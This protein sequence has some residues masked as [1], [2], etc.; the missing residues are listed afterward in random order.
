MT[1]LLSPPSKMILFKSRLSSLFFTIIFLFGAVVSYSQQALSPLNYN[2][3]LQ[4]LNKAKP[5]V[6]GQKSALDTIQVDLVNTRVIFR[7]DFSDYSGWPDTTKW[8]DK[9]AFINNSFGF[10]EFSYGVATFDG[11]DSA[12]QPYNIATPSAYGEN[13][14][15]TSCPI[16]LSVIDIFDPKMDSVYLSFYYQAQGMNPFGTEEGDSLILQFYNPSSLIWSSVWSVDGRP[17]SP[18]RKVTLL[19]DTQYHKN[20]FQ[21]RFVNY[22][23]QTGNVDHW[24]V[25]YVLMTYNEKN[26]H[27][28]VDDMAFREKFPTL[29]KEFTAMPYWHYSPS[30]MKNQVD[31][32]YYYFNNFVLKSSDIKSYLEVL[33][34]N[35][36][37][38]FL[39]STKSPEFSL[40]FVGAKTINLPF[41]PTGNHTYPVSPDEEVGYFKYKFYYVFNDASLDSNRANDTLIENQV[42]GSYYA[43]DDGMAEAGYGVFGSG[44]QLAYRFD[45][46]G[47]T[48]T[49]TGVYIYFTPV[50][51][52]R[53][54][55]RFQ[56]T[57]WNENG[58]TGGPGAELYR[59]SSFD[60][61]K[62]NPWNI[63]KGVSNF[64]YYPLETELVITGGPFY[65]GWTKVTEERMNIGYDVNT[66]S[67]KNI[68]VNIDGVWSQSDSS[69]GVVPGSLMMRPIFRNKKDPVIGMEENTSNDEWKV[70]PNPASNIL[71][72]R[73]VAGS[74]SD[75]VNIQIY[76]ITG[77]L[78][79]S[80]KGTTINVNDLSN[81]LYLIRILD[82]NDR[83]LHHEKLVV[84]H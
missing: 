60:R 24:N 39:D 46:R 59:K 67:Q 6:K 43:Y 8:V 3:H 53:T 19:V 31:L 12:G 18:F 41:N 84:R 33:D 82:A 51:E 9:E 4:Y 71:Q 26:D 54:T 61:P 66:N 20:G 56:L 70:F 40:G 81:G 75:P 44:N 5:H 79:R 21:F 42:F 2:T 50:V 58:L 7:D 57:V 28:R 69:G 55:E 1:Q 49:L 64:I 17:R 45:L 22:G 47:V 52:D 34:A 63:H 83:I 73:N 11:I 62:Y 29:L 76:S 25:D 78:M 16:N 80:V 38:V 15:L 37:R 65:I 27:A 30:D 10:R 32:E 14:H 23:N 35:G 13:D 36:N 74:N 77:S 48:D 72:I 68:F